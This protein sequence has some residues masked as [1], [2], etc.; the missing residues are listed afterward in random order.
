MSENMNVLGPGRP[1]GV[2]LL[3][4]LGMAPDPWQVEVLESHSRRILLNCS[5]QAGK[6]TVVAMFSLVEALYFP[7]SLVLLLSRSKRQ[8]GE[9]FRM[10]AEFFQRLESP[11]LKRKTQDELELTHGSRIVS[12]PCQADTIRGF[13]GVRVLVIDEAARVPDDLYRSVRPM[14]AASRGKMVCLST[15]YGKRG[16]FYESWAKGGPEWLRVEVPASKIS[17]IDPEHIE[18]DRRAFGE[19]YVRQEYFCSFEALEGLVYPGFVACKVDQLPRELRGFVEIGMPLTACAAQSPSPPEGRGGK[20]V[21]GID[22]GFNDPFVA[23]WG[24]L[25]RDDVLWIMGEHYSRRQTLG[26]HA[27]RLPRHARWYADPSGAREIAELRC[28]NFTISKAINDIAPGIAAVTG[29]LESGRLKVLASACPNLLA[30]AELYRYP[31]EKCDRRREVPI[32][33]DNH[34]MDALR[35]LVS[36][37]DERH[38]A[39]A[40][41]KGWAFWRKSDRDTQEAATP[42]PVKRPWLSV[43][44]EQL[45]TPLR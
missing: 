31:T 29:R 12:L 16:F 34:A 33:A 35:Y 26:Y 7:G 20:L 44:N 25:D 4:K 13:P 18:E 2:E 11:L 1:P 45:W 17:R 36:K 19:S 28:A 40:R 42:A 21:G 38:L 10:V 23:V 5:R 9:L 14:L 30:E 24:V 32:D 43:W 41:K 27:N 37:L 39:R 8:S 3:K 6:S 15:P 22:F